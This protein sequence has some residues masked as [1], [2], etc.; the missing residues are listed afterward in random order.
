MDNYKL[1]VFLNA[2]MLMPEANLAYD[3][4]TVN[5]PA[6]PVQGDVIN[7]N[8]GK[9]INAFLGLPFAETPTGSLRWRVGLFISDIV[10]VNMLNFYNR[11]LMSN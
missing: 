8:S 2:L 10:Y 1:F 11:L 3:H 5:M 4:V 7:L 9:K 6:G